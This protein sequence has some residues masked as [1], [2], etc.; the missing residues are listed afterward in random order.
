VAVNKDID[1]L[2][3]SLAAVGTSGLG[4]PYLLPG[5]GTR[6]LAKS[7]LVFSIKKTF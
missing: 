6:D 7:G 1:G 4:A 2:V 3:L 5:S